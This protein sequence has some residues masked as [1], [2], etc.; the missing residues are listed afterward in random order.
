MKWMRK[1]VIVLLALLWLEGSS[2]GQA[3][4]LDDLDSEYRLQQIIVLSRHNIRAPLAGPQS[5]MYKVTN[6]PWH[7]FGVASGELTARGAYME[8]KMGWYFRGYVEQK[9]LWLKGGK[10]SAQDICFTANG[11]QRTIATAENFAAG[12]CPDSGVKVNYKGAV[13]D[14]DPVFLPGTEGHK[15]V[16]A[17]KNAA[18]L[19]ALGGSDTLLAGIV[20]G[21]TAAAQ[22]FDRPVLSVEGLMIKVDDRLHVRGGLRPV[23][24]AC[25]A[26]TLQYYELGDSRASFGHELGFKEWQEIAAVKDLGIHVYRHVPT[27]ARAIASPML[28]VIRGELNDQ[29]RKFTFLC[30]HDTNVATVM[31]ALEVM[32]NSLPDTIE[33]EAPIGSK[34]VLEKWQDKEGKNLVRLQLVYPKTSQL[35][36]AEDLTAD[37]P[38]CFLTL[39]LQGIK[40]NEYGL[41]DMNAFQQ[42]LAD[43]IKSDEELR[44]ND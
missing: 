14:A 16:F 2:M 36:G 23:M 33:Q 11:F 43:A 35:I 9:N 44:D 21:L 13:G 8:R 7:D 1:L 30:G 10:P 12:F 22:V 3:A 39:H 5:A 18:E 31:G 28:S 40:T 29:A 17:E 25:D 26:L 42:R 37:N 32:E 6:H 34:L 20:P 38:P 27:L 15:A 24:Q 19:A 4:G 41:M